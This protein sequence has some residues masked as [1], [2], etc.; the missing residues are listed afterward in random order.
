MNTNDPLQQ[1]PGDDDCKSNEELHFPSAEELLREEPFFRNNFR[2]DVGEF[3]NR[4]E[5]EAEKQ[6]IWFPSPLQLALKGLRERL[7]RDRIQALAL[8][9][10]A[11]EVDGSFQEFLL[12][13]RYYLA[14]SGEP[15]AAGQI[16][17]ETAFLAIRDMNENRSLEMVGVT[18][19]WGATAELISGL[20]RF[21]DL[22]PSVGAVAH[23]RGNIRRMV[24]KAI[25]EQLQQRM[26]PLEELGDR[27]PASSRPPQVV[28]FFQDRAIKVPIGPY[29]VQERIT[30]TGQELIAIL[31]AAT[32]PETL[33][34]ALANVGLLIA[35]HPTEPGPLRN[36]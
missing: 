34:E 7:T 32:S 18:L 20:A 8:C 27:P 13:C 22:Q 36:P 3:C 23:F 2:E 24:K 12:R 29:Q 28:R 21:L 30:L 31:R 33:S 9:L 14:A 16:A 6:G 10:N 19:S 4:L 25:S 11:N 1:N 35:P 5:T 26:V 17:Q 15:E